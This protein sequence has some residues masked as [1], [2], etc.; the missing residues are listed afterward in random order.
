MSASLDQFRSEYDEE[1]LGMLSDILSTLYQNPERSVLR[2]YIA[3]GIDAHRISGYDGPV[4]VTLPSPTHPKLVIRDHGDG[5]SRED[6][7]RVYFSYVRST[8]RDDDTQIGSLGLG[9]KIAFALTKSWTV[10]NFHDGR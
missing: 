7:Q 9:A 2:E 5:L 4:E 1:S 8:K 6:M 3:N 10:T